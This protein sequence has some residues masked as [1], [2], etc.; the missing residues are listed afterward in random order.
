MFDKYNMS[1]TN[2]IFK[3]CIINM[4]IKWQFISFDISLFN[5]KK[6]HTYIYIIKLYLY[7][8]DIQ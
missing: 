4:M 6:V 7:I 8:V 2:I 1:I 5:I 3:K